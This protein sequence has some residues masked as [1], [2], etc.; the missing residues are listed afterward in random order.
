MR[1]F[2]FWPL[3]LLLAGC[4]AFTGKDNADPPSEL[5]ELQPELRI[6]TIWDAGFEDADETL[7]KLKPVVSNGVLY[8]AEPSG[9][10]FALDPETGDK[11]WSVDTD[12]PLSGGP[13]VADGLIAVGTLE[14]E[15][16]L[17]NGEDGGERWRQRVSSEVLSS[18]AI[19]DGNVVCR[20]TDGSVT[21][22]STDAGEK[23]WLYDR[24]VPVLTLRG[25]SSPLIT[26]YQVLAGF[27]GGKLVGLSLDTGLAEWE[28]TI[29]T[30]K[31]RTELERVVDIDADPVLVEGTLYVTAYQGD[32]AAVSESS[33]VVL[34]RRDISSHAGLDASWRQVFVTDSADHVWSLD[35]TN[36]ATLWQ[37][38][39]LHARKL[40]APA[41]VN[42]TVV[43][44]D[45]D[46]YVHWL[47]QEDGRQMARIRVGS[48]AIRLK[49]L[50]INDIVYVMDEGGT[51]SA[52]RA[53]PIETESR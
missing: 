34:W 47:S 10:V 2:I 24:S 7:L 3:L 41:M 21:A 17:L 26:D 8:I 42:D 46:G 5:V 33:G 16:I 28:A 18:P 39:K 15:L 53:H 20:T 40:S 1:Q 30:P 14:A 37:Q 32:V 48:D 52:L 25:D 50:V 12:S 27:A 51:L 11:H 19:N 31:G 29:S 36:G 35:A 6:E 13:G 43:V 44:G 4:S 45:F 23:R 22:Y 49:P 38:K 9:E